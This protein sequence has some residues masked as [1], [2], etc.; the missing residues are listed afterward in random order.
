MLQSYSALIENIVH[1]RWTGFH[2]VKDLGQEPT[3]DTG[4]YPLDSLHCKSLPYP[5]SW[6]VARNWILT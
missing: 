1:Q 6:E 4:L 2:G 5:L 3:L